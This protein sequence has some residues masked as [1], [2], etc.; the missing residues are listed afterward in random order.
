MG[1]WRAALLALSPALVACVAPTHYAWSGYD[2]VLYTHYKNPQDRQA[3]V[4]Q[5]KEVVLRSAQE[6]RR[7]P[8]GIYAEY[9]YALYEE[10]QL[11]EAVV[12]FK[13]E[14][15]LWPESRFLMEKMIRNVER[16]AGTAPPTPAQGPAGA[17]EGKG[18]P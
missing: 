7:V 4:A 6:G 15:D 5:L 8:P 13:K 17:L 11:Q 12:Y 2:D 3:F 9:G 18:S 1:L 10:G 14:H 16:R